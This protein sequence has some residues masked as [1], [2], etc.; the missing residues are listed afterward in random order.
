M[1]V[2]GCIFPTFSS[3]QVPC[4]YE[5]E[6]HENFL[7]GFLPLSEVTKEICRVLSRGSK[8]MSDKLGHV[9]NIFT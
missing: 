2:F 1:L 4:M 6:M 7:K 8:A 3:G 5:S 9:S